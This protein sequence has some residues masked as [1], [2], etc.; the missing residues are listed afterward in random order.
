MRNLGIILS[1]LSF[2]GI[3][4]ATE[5]VS[6]RDWRAEKDVMTPLEKMGCVAQTTTEV[7]DGQSSTEEWTLQVI[8]LATGNGDYSFPIIIS[9][10]EAQPTNEY[11]EASGQSNRPDTD[12]FSM[13]LM[14]PASG[15]KTIVANRLV[16]RNRIVN[17]LKADNTF[18]VDYLTKEGPTRSAEFSLRGSSV[19]IQRMLDTCN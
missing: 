9:F 11:Y 13:T 5:I 2:A 19:T 16:D 18:T 1:I 4:Q 8:K 12:A 17:R 14:Q 10:P 6:S 3:A 7:E 15:D